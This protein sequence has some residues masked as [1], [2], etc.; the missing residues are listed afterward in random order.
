MVSAN[1]RYQVQERAKFCCEYC[2]LPDTLSFY[3]H[4]VD[5]VIAVKHGGRTTLENLAYACWRCN[6]HKGS[7][8]GSF[9][10]ETGQFSFLFNPRIQP[11]SEH[12]RIDGDHLLGITPEGRATVRL[13]QLN[14]RERM[15]ER[16]QAIRGN[17]LSQFGWVDN[18]AE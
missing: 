12:F 5:H 3:P 18:Q 15:I 7:D 11:W 4:E 8:M 2:R 16:L 1:L 9:D 6:R 14:S 10:P 17:R 13:L